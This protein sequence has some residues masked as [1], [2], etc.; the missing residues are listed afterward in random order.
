MKINLLAGGF[1]ILTLIPGGIHTMHAQ[2]RQK[3]TLNDIFVSDKFRGKTIEDLQWLPD[4][5]AFTFTRKSEENG[6]AD[7]YRHQ[8]KT[9]QETLVL[10]SGELQYQGAA[11]EISDYQATG[12]QNFLLLTGKKKKIWRRSFT[13]PHYL[14]N[15]KTKKLIAL[16][17]N[18]PGL[19]TVALSPEGKWVAYVKNNNLY[20]AEVE[21]GESRQ[22]TF[23]GSEDIL[24]GVFDWVYEEEFGRADAYRWSPDGQKIAFWRTDQAR[25]KTFFL[26]DELPRYSAPEPMKYPKVGEQNAIVKI[27]VVDITT[28][29]TA[30]MDIGE[31]EDIYIPRIDW[32]NSSRTL[33]IQRLNR[34]QNQLE[35]LLAGADSGGSRVILTDADPAWVSVTNDFIF[36]KL[37]DRFVWTSEKSGY[38]HVYLS[39]YS[40]REIAQLTRGDWEVSSVIGVDEKEGWVYFYGRKDSPIEQHIYRV[41]LAGQNLQRISPAPLT[42][43]RA[44]F[45]PDF[46]HYVAFSSDARTPTQVSLCN[47]DGSLARMLEENQI[48]ALAEYGIVYPEFL[49]ITASDGAQ[50]NAWMMKPADFDPAKKYPVIVYGY[51]GPG[52]QTVTNQ[53]AGGEAFRSL[54]RT[55]WH[56][57]MTEKGYI[58]FSLDNRGAGGRGKAFKNLAYGDISKWAVQDQ[59]EGAKYL[60]GLPYVDASRIG[61]WGWSGGGYLTCMV[62]TRG[63]EYFVAGIAVA[64]VTDFRNYDTIWTERYMGL[65]SENRDGYEAANVLN[66]ADLLKGKLLL[67]HGGGDDNV[68]PQNTMQLAE[69]LI[70]QNKQFDMMLYPNRN[71]GIG[72]GNASRHLYALMVRYFEENL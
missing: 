20:V 60:A 1:F 36:L 34:K 30:W 27:G 32:T 64:P 2:P 56:Q 17:K 26:L 29:K 71:H 21:N 54:Q 61:F 59:I 63:A 22:L 37:S 45:S 58:I 51:G 39:D 11:V 38:R 19:Q 15:M 9:G 68:H 40:G 6:A 57:F 25:V 42:W 24:N 66:Y 43:H 50:L 4:G 49:T 41:S 52:S 46:R 67:I 44:D 47:S 33:A 35:L 14:Y 16:A 5:S 10:K 62:L 13:A 12:M 18:D 70:A 48:P 31:N 28:G 65:L 72:G 69:A 55:L 23:D 8:V 7:I 3:L 53:W